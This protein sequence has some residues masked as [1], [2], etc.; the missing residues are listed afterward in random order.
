M[1]C[2][3]N[4]APLNLT[5]V[6]SDIQKCEVTCNY[7]F[8]YGASTCKV[9]P[10]SNF[11]SYKY[12]GITVVTYNASDPGSKYN[13]EEIRIYSPPLNNYTNNENDAVAELF[14]HHTSEAT[15]KN[16][17]V[18]VPLALN[19]A[20]SKS[21]ELLEQIISPS[22]EKQ[23]GEQSINVQNFTLDNLIPITDYYQYDGDIPYSTT[24]NN[25]CSSQNAHIILFPANGFINMNTKTKETL[26]S[27]IIATNKQTLQNPSNVGLRYNKN[28]T[29]NNTSSGDDIYIEC[30]SLDDD[31]NVIETD[32]NNENIGANLEN[33]GQSRMSDETKRKMLSIIFTVL[34]VLLALLIIYFAGHYI[35]KYMQALKN[36]GGSNIASKG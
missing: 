10:N 4:L 20:S 29:I 13:V 32:G 26:K 1:A 5:D 22:I 34:G 15:G 19:D 11:L 8:S 21:S 36:D 28:G 2:T 6:K 18:C 3:G 33:T 23:G 12:D 35:W 9:T 7:Q 14:I 31:G 24:G 25:I 27:L 17:L 16:L 30:K